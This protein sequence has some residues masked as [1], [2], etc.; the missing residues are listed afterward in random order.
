VGGGVRARPGEVSLAHGGI[1]FLDELAEWQRPHLDALRQTIETR[2]A[3]VSRANH[4]ITYP[5]KFQ[6]I[7]AMNPCR[8]G[9]L[10]DPARACAR[11]PICSQQ[12]LA[13]ISG[14][15]LDR[16]DLMIEVPEVPIHQMLEKTEQESSATIRERVLAAQN[17]AA[18]R[19]QGGSTRLNAD[20]S[21]DEIDQ[22]VGLDDD[23]LALLHQAGEKQALSA[24]G[25][26]RVLR[27]AR[28]IADL[29]GDDQTRSTHLAEALRYRRLPSES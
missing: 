9:Y 7:A 10:G 20:L 29:D 27:V 4:H 5:A 23:A 13:K 19:H 22:A 11:A 28:T 16:F 21:P 25:L 1:L 18:R 8:C 14:P 17:F 3:V 15:M 12:Y 26:H 6:L 24:R 2:K